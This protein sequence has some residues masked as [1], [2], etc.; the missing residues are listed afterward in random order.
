MQECIAAINLTREAFAA[1]RL[2]E[3]AEI[4]IKVW[5]AAFQA[6]SERLE[7]GD[8]DGAVAVLRWACGDIHKMLEQLMTMGGG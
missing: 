6:M 8:H 1:G 4:A 5:E 7:A 3:Q 2:A